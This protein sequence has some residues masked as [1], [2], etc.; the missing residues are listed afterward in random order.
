MRRRATHLEPRR[1]WQRHS[2]RGLFRKILPVVIRL[3]RVPYESYSRPRANPAAVAI[4]A[5]SCGSTK[6]RALASAH[7]NPGRL[8]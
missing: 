7:S 6:I 3:P 5:I 1:G 8:K 4:F 2:K